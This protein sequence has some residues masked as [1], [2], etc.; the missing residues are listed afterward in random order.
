MVIRTRWPQGVVFVVDRDW[1]TDI[2]VANDSS[3]Q[4]LW[5]NNGEGTFTEI[6]LLASVGYNEDGKTFAG[7]GTD[8]ADVGEDGFPDIVTTALPYEYYAYF[9]RGAFGTCP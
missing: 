6:G 9:R 1:F 5:R 8:F 3:P 4:F 7:M 2:T